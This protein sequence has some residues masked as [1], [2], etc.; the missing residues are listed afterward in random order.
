[1]TDENENRPEANQAAFR[2]HGGGQAQ[3]SSDGAAVCGDAGLGASRGGSA[4][5]EAPGE[6]ART[7]G[8]SERFALIGQPAVRGIAHAWLGAGF[9]VVP[10]KT[11]GSKRPALP[12]W[13]EYQSA[14]PTAREVDD[15]F[16]D[17]PVPPGIGLICGA[18]SGGLEMFELEGRAVTEGAFA[19]LTDAMQEHDQMDVWRRLLTGY[20]ERSPSGGIHLLYRV[21]PG[22]A[23]PNTKL[24]RRP[25][26][27]EELAEN[28]AE[29]VKVLIET[30]GEGG[31]VI[32][33]PTGGHC[34]PSGQ[35][36]TS[37]SGVPGV[38]PI[39][40][41]DERDALYAIAS[42][43]DRMPV[44]QTPDGAA[45][46]APRSPDHVG[47]SRPGDDFNARATWD[48]ILTPRGWTKMRRVGKGFGWRR[49]GKSDRSIAATT[50]TSADGA[51][52][53]Y[54]FSTSTEL[55]T[56]QP[57]TK[58]TVYALLD[59]G[60][61]YSAA[62]KALR[63]H[64]YGSGHAQAGAAGE[65]PFGT[66]LPASQVSSLEPA[67][68][69]PAA[70]RSGIAVPIAHS[71][72]D[73]EFWGA[74]RTH[75]HIRQSARSRR[76]APWAVLAVVLARITAAIEPTIVLPALVGGDGSLNTFVALVGR[77][78]SGKG[79]AEAVANE[80]ILLPDT[81]R[82]GIGSGEGLLHAYV[83]SRRATQTAPGGIEQHTS[84]VIFTAAEVDQLAALKARQGSTLIP[85]LRDAWS[86]AQ[87]SFAYVDETKRLTV[88]AHK[89]RLCLIVGV[90]PGRAGV[91]LD[92]AEGGTPQR[93][94]WMPTA[95]PDVPDRP[96]PN[97]GTL[98]WTMP[99]LPK[100]DVFSGRRVLPVCAEARAEI[101]A[102]TVA[103]HRGQFN[104]LD[105]HA[106]QCRLKVAAALGAL[107]GRF[108]VTGEDWR[109]SATVMDVSNETRA[110]VQKQLAQS[111]T[112]ANRARGRADGERAAI[113]DDAREVGARRRVVEA[114]RRLLSR[115]P[116]G[117]SAARRNLSSR[118]RH[119]FN[120]ALASLLDTGEV[121]EEASGGN[122]T[123]GTLLRL[124]GHR[125]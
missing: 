12:S 98:T 119:V 70:S 110:A 84:R 31:F 80:M 32:I 83:T 95:D 6:P 90:Q 113:V 89:Y 49:P 36:W 124:S 3:H 26:T 68:N 62:A 59:H 55:P 30:R 41:A 122:G 42:L 39:I 14:P 81:K 120:D 25:A 57:L 9:A 125:P 101:D 64:G 51:D 44:E 28:P 22:A 20:M 115:G 111:A 121:V 71:V 105:G 78:G 103:R 87:L 73:E 8:G 97:P 112:D 48:E 33:A 100:P 118:D 79:A 69:V 56:E 53:L 74:R 114:I 50:G 123:Q 19:L 107:D 18:V 86:G 88:Q 116:I 102:A 66:G 96:P 27:P 47:G 35:P 82:I 91:L 77:S 99:A 17:T 72:A 5:R 60:G 92:D 58:F 85:T 106:L 34:H 11:D 13:K 16:A 52:R 63:A 23:R 93:F 54:V 94:L 43:F 1:M 29:K 37:P 15:W 46:G 104:P 109:L 38:V 40:T 75:D 2:D 7:D 67:Q 10:V 65:D 108:G 21:R 24:A 117:R 61:D 4:G 45:P 76:V